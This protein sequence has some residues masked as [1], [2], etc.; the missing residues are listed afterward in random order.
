MELNGGRVA[1]KDGRY[2]PKVGRGQEI[3]ADGAW[4]QG[5]GKGRHRDAP[6]R[7]PRSW[8]SSLPLGG[9]RP[10]LAIDPALTIDPFLV[11]GP[12]LVIYQAGAPIY[13]RASLPHQHARNSGNLSRGA[14]Y[15]T[16]CRRCSPR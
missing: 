2:A 4:R 9:G 3:H 14:S 6:R 10:A 5:R 12:L 15:L 1:P 8:L 7:S 16:R 13:M 11:I